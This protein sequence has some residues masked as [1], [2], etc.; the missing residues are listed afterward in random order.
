MS[1]KL[2]DIEK[3]NRRVDRENHRKLVKHNLFI[4]RELYQIIALKESYPIQTLYNYL[5]ADEYEAGTD[6]LDRKC[7][8]KFQ[9]LMFD[10]V[11]ISD[12]AKKKLID[13]GISSEYFFTE[14]IKASESL[15]DDI[16]DY[17]EDDK[18][19]KEVENNDDS[20]SKIK[21]N[22][23]AILLSSIR[24]SILCEY[25]T[26]VNNDGTPLIIAITELVKRANNCAI[27]D[28]RR[29]YT[30]TDKIA[31]FQ[32]PE[33]YTGKNIYELYKSLLEQYNQ[34][35]EA[36]IDVSSITKM[37][38]KNI[39]NN[40]FESNA[41][42]C[43]YFI[44]RELLKIFAEL[45]DVGNIIEKFYAYLNISEAEYQNIINT[46]IANN[47]E[48]VDKLI[49][50]K[51][52]SNMFRGDKPAYIL[53]HKSLKNEIKYYLSGSQNK[54]DYEIFTNMLKLNILYINHLENVTLVF[55]VYNLFQTLKQ[56]DSSSNIDW[57][58]LIQRYPEL[59]SNSPLQ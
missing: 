50:F 4:I 13:C 15:E 52:P 17:L 56:A 38:D 54:L 11:N 12:S 49:P 57:N 47:V 29:V 32:S 3:I 5:F 44:I 53:M 42:S 7:R 24:E 2:T 33:L 25:E 30:L 35:M 45:D 37:S 43:N 28:A 10:T 23:E 9:H 26:I 39:Y 36:E 48:L 51:F 22:P 41:I 59:L 18:T 20:F 58:D 1:K 31:F 40:V 6:N 8:D 14:F 21:N 46:G 27:T 34:D 19:Y 55:P 16:N